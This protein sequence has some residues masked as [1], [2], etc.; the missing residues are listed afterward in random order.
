M[1]PVA[2]DELLFRRIPAST[3]WYDPVTKSISPEA[4]RPN[5]ND[6]TG[7]SFSRASFNPG[8]ASDEA[9]RGRLGKQYYVSVLRAADLRAAG[10]DVIPKP[11]P[12]SNPG[13]AEAPALNYK[14]RRTNEARE[15]VQQFRSLVLEVLGPFDGQTDPPPK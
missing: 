1:E 11:Q 9:A 15:I 3:G 6:T 14:D 13:H 8:G 4:F 10:I 12:P 5:S 2:D 7:L